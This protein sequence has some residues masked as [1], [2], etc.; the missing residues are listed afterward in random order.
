M[1]KSQ[2][3]KKRKRA[4]FKVMIGLILILTMAFPQE[5]MV[6][7]A[8]SQTQVSAEE[9][10]QQVE[11]AGAQSENATASVSTSSADDTGKSTAVTS[12]T[13]ES[14]GDDG[15]KAETTPGAAAT[16]FAPS[17]EVS[18]ST[19]KK[20]PGSVQMTAQEQGGGTTRKRYQY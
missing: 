6:M 12:S 5:S 13:S 3:H 11:T 9:S 18:A 8:D 1:K 4:I 17:T 14:D 19:I 7:A 20:A 10:G 2:K 16:E 15:Q